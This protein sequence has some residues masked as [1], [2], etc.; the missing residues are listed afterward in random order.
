MEQTDIEKVL[1]EGKFIINVAIITT[2]NYYEFEIREYRG[3]KYFINVTDES[4]EEIK[5]ISIEKIKD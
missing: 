5:F 1:S 4:V 3:K 2:N